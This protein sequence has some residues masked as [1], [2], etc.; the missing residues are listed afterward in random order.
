MVLLG[1][2]GTPVPSQLAPP[3]AWNASISGIGGHVDRHREWATW[4]STASSNVNG[5]GGWHLSRLIFQ[6]VLPPL[7]AAKY[8]LVPAASTTVGKTSVST[9]EVRDVGDKNTS[10]FTISNGAL[11]L[12]FGLSGL[13]ENAT[14]TTGLQEKTEHT[15]LQ[16]KQDFLL[17]WGNGGKDGPGSDPDGTGGD[18]KSQSDAYVFSPQGPASSVVGRD[19]SGFWPVRPKPTVVSATVRVAGPVMDEVSTASSLSQAHLPGDTSSLGLWH[20]T[21]IFRDS[22]TLNHEGAMAAMM[23]QAVE[24]A[25]IVNP[26][27]SNQDLVMRISTGRS[28][29][30]LLHSDEAGWTSTATAL[31]QDFFSIQG[32]IG[33]NFLPVSSF[34][35]VQGGDGSFSVAMLTDRARGAASLVD[36]AVEM[37]LHRHATGGNGRGPSDG[38]GDGVRSSIT[39]L[40]AVDRQGYLTAQ[41]M[42]PELALR[43]W[44]P[45]TVLFGL[46]V[47]STLSTTAPGAAARV[48]GAAMPAWSWSPLSKPLPPT[49][50]LL[51]FQRRS[52]LRGGGHVPDYP[53]HL[54]QGALR[55]Q[56]VRN[57]TAD[58][59]SSSGTGTDGDLSVESSVDLSTLFRKGVFDFDLTSLSE[60]TLSL[61]RPAAN[62]TRRSWR[63]VGMTSAVVTPA[64]W[65]Y[66][67]D[68]IHE[69]GETNSSTVELRPTQIRSFT[70]LLPAL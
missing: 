32:K 28:T 1:P 6:A 23:L 7:G 17:Y 16:L 12:A 45:M 70:F 40:P 15:T 44:H 68:L 35:E 38:D 37:V 29:S 9:V 62:V 63:G 14:A 42:R 55:L 8:M 27:S 61:A 25:H 69:A 60:R 47:N 31:K 2:D 50:H 46:P 36:G 59:C 21:R 41:Q 67:S 10:G 11:S 5:Q 34:A 4:A 24:S 26:L 43:K 48:S 20:A 18:G 33:C 19:D 53:G 39:L 22:S 64:Q 52:F 54:P 13:I 65:R 30:N 56:Q 66:P 3:E 57:S 51:S 49:V 58:V